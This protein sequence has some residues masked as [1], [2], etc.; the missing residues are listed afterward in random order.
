MV[1]LLEDGCCCARY[2]VA[3]ALAYYSLFFFLLTASFSFRIKINIVTS[4]Y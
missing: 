2:A 1:A 3:C 4:S